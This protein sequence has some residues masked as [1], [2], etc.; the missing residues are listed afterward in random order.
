MTIYDADIKKEGIEKLN[1]IFSESPYDLTYVG[2]R[3]QVSLN[4]EGQKVPLLAYS[5]KD[6][7]IFHGTVDSIPSEAR[8]AL[9]TKLEEL[10]SLRKVI[11][12][13]KRTG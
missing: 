10:E 6:I 12:K 1:R 5:K 8:T 7:C 3:H 13:L 4:L 9:E 11:K 2:G